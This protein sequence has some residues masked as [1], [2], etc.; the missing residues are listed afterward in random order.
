M[1]RR[2][3]DLEGE[4]A[5]QICWKLLRS[6]YGTRPAAQDWA[7]TVRSVVVKLGFAPPPR[8]VVTNHFPP[9]QSWNMEHGAQRRF[10]LVRGAG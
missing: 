4:P 6:M 9:S 5:G 10:L 3:A 1:S 2:S 7:H 8:S